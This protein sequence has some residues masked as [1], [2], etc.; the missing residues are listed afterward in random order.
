[1]AW[2]PQ[3]SWGAAEAIVKAGVR[4]RRTIRFVLFSGEEQGLL[5]SYA[6]VQ[7]HQ[8][9]MGNHLG[10]LVLDEGQ[11]PVKELQLGG[12]KDLVALFQPFLRVVANIRPV[13]VND[14]VEFGS[15]TGPFIAAGLPGINMQQD[16][17]DYK[18]THHSAADAVEAVK[19]EGTDAGRDL[20]GVDRVLDRGSAR[21]VGEALACGQDG[22]CFAGTEPV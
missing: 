15:D 2:A 10:D 20:D 17:P 14:K 21:P 22:P 7:Q 9:E 5:G 8:A 12:R 3:A 19:P 6:Y 16:S 11:G 18:Y 4:P 13:N 1:M